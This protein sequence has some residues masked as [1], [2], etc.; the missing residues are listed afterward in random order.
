MRRV[1]LLALLLG[2]LAR[3]SL[4]GDAAEE[5]ATAAPADTAVATFAGG[6]FWCLEAPFDA[7]EGV[8]STTSGYTGG[9]VDAPSYE[10]VS[11][12]TTG[13]VEAVRVHYDPEQ[14]DYARLLE[15]FWRNVD[16]LDAGG[17]FCDRGAQYRSA[18]FV[19]D[20]TQRRLA[21]DSRRALE[22]RLD[23]PVATEILEAGPFHPAEAYHQDYY[24]ANPIRYR[25]Y[26]SRCGRDARLEAVWGDEAG[27]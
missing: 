4:G 24:R 25:F 22:G 13:H 19:H 8:L 11:S 12:G 16:P 23:G 14:V 9:H 7:L 15:V 6:C 2:G 10:Q 27:P 17:Q 20:A 3:A 5:P 1:V 18:V 26:R 21:A